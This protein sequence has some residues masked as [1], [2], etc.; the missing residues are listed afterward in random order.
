MPARYGRDVSQFYRDNFNAYASRTAGGS[1]LPIGS[2]LYLGRGDAIIPLP[3]AGA[4]RGDRRSAESEFYTR[5]A[6]A[7]MSACRW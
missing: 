6:P 3:F 7:G 5:R 2:A 1:V 4:I